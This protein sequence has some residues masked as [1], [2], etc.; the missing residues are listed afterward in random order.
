MIK[1]PQR[2]IL[3][4]LLG[5]SLTVVIL[6][7]ILLCD[8][9]EIFKYGDKIGQIL[10]NLSLAYIASYIFYFVVVVLK[11]K[12]DKK[13][14]YLSVYESTKHLVGRAYSVYNYIVASSGTDNQ[15][16]DKKTITKEQFKELCKLANPNAIPKNKKLGQPNGQDAT[17]GRFIYNGAVSYVK[18]YTE[19]IFNYM[20]FLD[21]EHVRLINRLYNSNFFLVADSLT[22]PTKNTDFSV[23][24]DN[25]F[26]FLE[27]V[28][29]LDNY[30]ETENKK[31][32][33][34]DVKEK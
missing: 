5:F 9:P 14:I 2:Q 3:L 31:H 13:N 8:M 33:N 20:P 28:R 24:A 34:I 26:E 23:Y 17:Y 19:R 16:Y 18:L 1:L 27:F 30:N 11:E 22:W 32:I 25:M 29:E 12:Q 21:S 7:D 10:S 6:N 15:R 4:I